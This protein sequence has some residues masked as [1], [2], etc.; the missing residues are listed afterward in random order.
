M[1][2]KDIL[3][4]HER[5][6]GRELNSFVSSYNGRRSTKQITPIKIDTL[7]YSENI[8]IPSKGKYTLQ[9]RVNDYDGF[10]IFGYQHNNKK[11]V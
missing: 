6:T 4:F 9:F 11:L 8:E 2:F 10:C 3:I 7:L 5:D 1:E